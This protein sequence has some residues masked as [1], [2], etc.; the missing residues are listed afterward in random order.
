VT[1][2]ELRAYLQTR[3]VAVVRSG[4]VFHV[5]QPAGMP[6][7]EWDAV[8]AT[9]DP[10]VRRHQWA[11]NKHLLDPWELD[12]LIAYLD[13]Y[14]IKIVVRAN[15]PEV[16]FPPG[17]GR[18]WRAYHAATLLPHLRHWRDKLRAYYEEPD[19]TAELDQLT[20]HA[21][22]PAGRPADERAALF[23]GLV[24]MARGLA[25]GRVAYFSPYTRHTG[26]LPASATGFPPDAAKATVCGAAGDPV[27]EW[28]TLP[29]HT[30]PAGWKWPDG[31]P[32]PVGCNPP[33]GWLAE[34]P[35]SI[36]QKR[37]EWYAKNWKT[38]YQDGDLPD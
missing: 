38:N 6:A 35:A 12:R 25:G 32:L 15:R 14:E 13:S 18:V 16:A 22:W 24:A 4:P 37:R 1:F 30:P 17:M 34:T 2:P 21:V 29:A 3:A 33:R 5:V 36:K 23:G 27:G 7:D 31:K 20:R 11:V 9:I 28:L 26:Y 19:H 10:W 8:L